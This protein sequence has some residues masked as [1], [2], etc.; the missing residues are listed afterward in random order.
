MPGR[1]PFKQ[2]RGFKSMPGVDLPEVLIEFIPQGSYVKVSAVDPVSLT[3]VA[4]VGDPSAGEDALRRTAIK[5]LQYVLAKAKGVK[6]KD[7]D[8]LAGKEIAGG[9]SGWDV[10]G[11]RRNPDEVGAAGGGSGARS[12]W[13]LGRKKR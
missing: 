9:V 4:I 2:G 6:V 3:E 1:Q 11:L 12:G 5:K 10:P 13:D 7:E 8:P